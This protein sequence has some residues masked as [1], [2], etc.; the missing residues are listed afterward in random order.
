[1]RKGKSIGRIFGIVLICLTI[2]ASLMPTVLSVRPVL[3]ATYLDYVKVYWDE[4][5]HHYVRNVPAGGE[6]TINRNPGSQVDVRIYRTAAAPVPVLFYTGDLV[7][8]IHR[9]E[10]SSNLWADLLDVAGPLET[11]VLALVNTT[12]GCAKINVNNL[13]PDL[14]VS[15]TQVGETSVPPEEYHVGNTVKVECEVWNDGPGDAESSRLGY[16]IGTS[17]T[18]TSDRWEDGYVAAL[19][20][21]EKSDEYEYYTFQQS[22]VGTR[23]FV[24]KADYQN[25]VDEGDNEGNNKAHFG[26]FTVEPQ[27]DGPTA[28]FSADVTS[29]CEPLNV[30]FTDLS[31][32][33]SN[34]ITSWYWQFGD[35]DTS[36]VQNPSNSYEADTC[37]VSLTVTDSHGYSDTETKENYITSNEGPTAA[38]SADP[39]SGDAPLEVDFFDNSVPGD[40]PIVSWYW[41]FGNG[42]TSTSQNPNYTYNTVDTYTVTLTVTDSHGC[43]DSETKE[44]YITVTNPNPL[45]RFK[46]Y[47]VIDH[48][49]VVCGL[50]ELI[51]RMLL[52]GNTLIDSTVIVLLGNDEDTEK[53]E[54]RFSN[55]QTVSLS[56]K[57]GG[58]WSGRVRLYPLSEPDVMDILGWIGALVAGL[59]GMP[60]PFAPPMGISDSYDSPPALI[61]IA[62]MQSSGA[63]YLFTESESGSYL[64]CYFSTICASFDLWPNLPFGCSSS[65]GYIAVL[66]PVDI[67]VTDPHGLVIS[68]DYSEVDDASYW[69]ND[70]NED[71]DPEEFIIIKNVKEGRYVVTVIPEPGAAPTDTYT[72]KVSAGNT[73]L[74]L[75]EDVQISETPEQ[76]YIVESTEEGIEQIIPEDDTFPF[77]FIATAAYGTPMAEETQILR[78]FRDGYLLTNPLGQAF[79]NLY[80]T[81]SPPLAGFITDHPSLKPM[82]RAGL[83]PAVVMS[84]VVVN[85]TPTEKV[86]TLGVLMLVSVAIVI[87]GMTRRRGRGQEYS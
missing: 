43:S 12:E 82:V 1:M 38:F 32:A 55:S 22:D 31:T 28:D 4:N 39:S 83:V 42:D 23:Y 5:E 41:Q 81:V 45:P 29:C 68:K 58:Q 79:V 48:Y 61:E 17:E 37:T 15:N 63:T 26:P 27:A 59:C 36:T 24:F 65:E 34:P 47:D 85:T 71:G 49:G 84:A 67:H 19:A 77:C 87:W 75:A 10:T 33:G 62:V 51:D 52:G 9:D 8:N 13:V 64:P 21:E 35:G 76:G 56:N 72:L 74:V 50:T 7:N 20:A 73:T 69:N 18:D 70:Y 46:D 78:D 14:Y 6:T 57:G 53:V 16:Y 30:Q 11:R 60:G 44:E 40:N 25:E 3:A 2:I 80:Y 86:A 54:L 66:S